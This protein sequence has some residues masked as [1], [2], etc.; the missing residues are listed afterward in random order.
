MSNKRKGS[1]TEH[2]GLV[3]L[4]AG[5][6][7]RLARDVA[8]CNSFKHLAAYPKPLLPLGGKALLSHWREQ[9]SALPS[10]KEVVVVTND[11]HRTLY[12]QWA[13]S[14]DNVQVISDGTTS[15]ENR[16]GAIAAMR[17]GVS[18]LSSGVDVAVI[19][20]GDTLLPTLDACALLSEFSGSAQAVC[21]YKL[22]DMNDCVRRG[23]LRVDA[24]GTA[25]DLV[26]KPA[27]PAESPSDLACAPV[28]LLTRAMFSTFDVFFKE[29]A[30]APLKERDA[31]GFWVRWA[32]KKHS[33]KVLRVGDR[34]D[35][36]G[37]AHYR[38]AL[39]RC[40]APRLGAIDILPRTDEEPAV[41][42]A[43]PRAGV[44]GNPSDGYGGKTIAIAL[45]SEG[46]AEVIATPASHFSVSHND[47][48]EMPHSF[49][50]IRSLS[51]SVRRYGVNYGARQLVLAACAAFARLLPAG[52][53]V[54]PN[55]TVSYE[56]TI[57]ARLGLAGSS[58]I[59]L[60]TLRALSRFYKTSLPKLD[61]AI[62][63]WPAR[64]LAVE[65]ELLGIEGG[66]MDR[67][68]QVYQGCMFMDF[69]ADKPRYT[70]LDHTLLPQLWI[71]YRADA[72]VGECSGKVHS[73]LRKR[74][75]NCDEAVL[76]GMRKLGQVAEMGRE[77]LS[78]NGDVSKLPHLMCRN[79]K[80]R[81]ELVGENVVG[82]HN[83]HLVRTAEKA[84]FAA[85][86]CGSGGAVI[87]VADPVSALKEEQVARARS[88]FEDEGLVLRKVEVLSGAEWSGV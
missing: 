85:K 46:H 22:R 77:A 86:M 75:C 7:T 51:D 39:S 79:F 5:Y 74:F 80:L 34:I 54:M 13:R 23:M 32:V 57:A 42:R 2:V 33:T 64:V 84:G 25:V 56:T 47:A 26:E 9:F 40:C 21:A 14:F 30:D 81:L 37:L 31:P 15:N 27:S 83:M 10:F 17:L 19:V 41:G 76:S 1:P 71:V 68:A 49:D 70:R 66:L 11:A 87:C 61:P 62:E 65:R 16:T 8:A 52:S 12:E 20:A 43:Y 28:Y 60:A 3:L 73:D 78:A 44:L 4:A 50:S 18:E 67:V 58:A 88:I 38:D 69:S 48:H 63:S 6:G 55:C 82:D 35:I 45:A 59:I 53:G 24:S 72:T 29:N 36:G